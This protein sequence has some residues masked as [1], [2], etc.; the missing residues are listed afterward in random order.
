M[1]KKGMLFPASIQL[2]AWR[3]ERKKKNNTESLVKR[4]NKVTLKGW[5]WW[6]EGRR[7]GMGSELPNPEDNGQSGQLVSCWVRAGQ[8]PVCFH[9]KSKTRQMY[10]FCV[11]FWI[12]GIV[13]G[14]SGR[15][16]GGVGISRIPSSSWGWSG[17]AAQLLVVHLLKEAVCVLFLELA[18]MPELGIQKE[19]E[20]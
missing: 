12:L 19:A 15:G 17:A 3:K 16:W 6:T 5:M 13:T 10:T 18:N 20:V 14:C 8:A 9:V 4:R 11:C 7:T 2:S 1:L